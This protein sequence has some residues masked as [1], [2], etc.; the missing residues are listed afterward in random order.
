M[1]AMHQRRTLGWRGD[2]LVER[3]LGG[4]DLFVDLVIVRAVY[5][6]NGHRITIGRQRGC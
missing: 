5:L 6:S 2:G 3:E 1:V 4:P